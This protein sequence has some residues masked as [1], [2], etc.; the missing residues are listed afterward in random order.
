VTPR[1]IAFKYTRGESPAVAIHSA[2]GIRRIVF[3]TTIFGNDSP[4]NRP[5]A[6]RRGRPAIQREVFYRKRV[7][8]GDVKE[9]VLEWYRDIVLINYPSRR[10]AKATAVNYNIIK[11]VD[12]IRGKNMIG[13]VDNIDA[14]V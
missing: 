3:K 8:A 4:V 10:N 5:A 1:C 6:A 9:T 11:N 12:V 7:S 2:A 14:G 13:N